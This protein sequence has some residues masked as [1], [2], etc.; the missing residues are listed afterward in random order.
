MNPVFELNDLHVSLQSH[1][2]EIELVRGVSFAV[3][4]GEC[5]G[6]LGESG[7]G[8][9]MSMKAAMGLLDHSFYVKGS[10]QFQGEELLGK[11]AEEL[12]R[13]R[14]GKVGIILQNPMTCFDPLYRI[15]QQI[16]E[17]FSAHNNWTAEEIRVRSLELLK[18]MRI[19]NPEEVLEK[20]PHQL[21]GGM[22]Q[23]IMIGIATAMKPALLIADEPTTAIDAITQYEILNELLQIKENH[24]TAMIFISHDL[25]AISRV[26]D[27]IVVLNHGAVVDRGDFQHILHHAQD[28]YTK[29]LVEKRADVMRRY[30][31]VL[32]GKKEA[33]HA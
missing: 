13:L 26:A 20:Y 14:G 24:N 17:T 31:T 16:A 27:R 5:L 33:A 19:R 21:S 1:H 6:I 9:S 32:N 15:G 23:R 3:A 7:S 29:L 22:L 10:A 4:P 11:S 30:T 28:P 8:K 2:K 25:N 12:R 18:K